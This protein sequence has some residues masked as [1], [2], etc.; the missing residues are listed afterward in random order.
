MQLTN[1]AQHVAIRKKSDL[2]RDS[3][4]S[5]DNKLKGHLPVVT[6]QMNDLS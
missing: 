5:E 4:G 2:K 1:L 6:S 3:A